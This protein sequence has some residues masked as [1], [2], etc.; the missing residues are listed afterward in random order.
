MLAQV[1]FTLDPTCNF[2]GY[3]L[4]YW[5]WCKLFTDSIFLPLK[6]FHH[7]C[8]SVLILNPHWLGPDCGDDC[9]LVVAFFFSSLDLFCFGL[10]IFDCVNFDFTDWVRFCS[11]WFIF[12]YIFNMLLHFFGNPIL[13]N[14]PSRND[15][16][17][18]HGILP[19]LIFFFFTFYSLLL[20]Y[21]YS[22]CSTSFFLKMLFY[23]LQSALTYFLLCIVIMLI[24]VYA[25]NVHCV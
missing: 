8:L 10:T 12:P 13:C 23:S 1:I 22:M 11:F 19:F 14:S 17:Q 24:L 3:T 4:P 18:C 9:I 5:I 20:F 6:C 21:A 16:S 7:Q 15:T 25:Y 2:K